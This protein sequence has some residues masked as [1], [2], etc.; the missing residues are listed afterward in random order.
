[1]NIHQLSANIDAKLLQLDQQLI[2]L[3]RQSKQNG[4]DNTQLMQDIAALET[5]KSKL[6]KSR[7]L[8]WRAHELQH[9]DNKQ[10]R[11]K[12]II[13]IGLC[14][15]CGLGLLAIGILMVLR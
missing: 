14:V 6:K 15:F 10:L 4:G 2:Q 3:R 12:R 8:A 5:L 1:M 7:D 11:Q 9:D 13:G